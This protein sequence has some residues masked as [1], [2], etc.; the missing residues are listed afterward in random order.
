MK[1][2]KAGVPANWLTSGVGE[3]RLRITEG[4][5]EVNSPRAMVAKEG[6]ECRDVLSANASHWIRTG[7]LVEVRGDRVIFLGREDTLINVGGSKVIPEEV[8]NVLLG[9]PGIVQARVYG[10]PNPITGNLV[11]ADV[12]VS[13]AEQGDVRSKLQAAFAGNLERYKQPRIIRFLDQIA[14]SDTGKVSRSS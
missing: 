3:A 12:V 8:E 7:D 10:C 5:L 13:G 2:G 1:D 6:E 9:I 11:C 4:V 14:H